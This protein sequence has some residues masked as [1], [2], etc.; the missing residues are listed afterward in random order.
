MAS[1]RTLLVSF[2]VMGALAGTPGSA[3]DQAPPPAEGRSNREILS[4]PLQDVQAVDLV[5]VLSRLKLLNERVAVAHV[6][7][8]NA[9]ILAGDSEDVLDLQK[10]ILQ[11]AETIT[12]LAD[13]RTPKQAPAVKA[14]SLKHLKAHDAYQEVIRLYDPLKRKVATDTQR[15]RLLAHGDQ[16]TLQQVAALLEIIDVPAA[17]AE[18]S[19]NLQVRV[20]W[21]VSKGLADDGGKAPP[22]DL[23]AVITALKQKA[24]VGELAMAAQAIVNINAAG[25]SF[26][27]NGTA[28]LQ[29]G[30]ALFQAQGHLMDRNE[31]A[32]R[33]EASLTVE[34]EGTRPSE[35]AGHPGVVRPLTS[36][37]TTITARSGQAIV[38]GMTPIDSMESIFVIQLLE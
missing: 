34:L 9:L 36:L 22:E 12:A 24:G 27:A 25:S 7:E 5:D 14:F 19:E 2:A 31:D 38:L 10:V 29:L 26:I 13:R 33:V 8:N 21:L 35:R 16:E 20:V 37:Q 32:A 17:T 15:N 4:V 6:P 18:G 11:L 30:R 28:E 3:A 1:A 23:A